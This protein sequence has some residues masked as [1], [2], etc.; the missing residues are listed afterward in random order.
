M[1]NIDNYKNN[2]EIESS[3]NT[4]SIEGM[5]SFTD[6]S[7]NDQVQG[8]SGGFLITIDT[9]LNE[10]KIIMINDHCQELGIVFKLKTT[11]LFYK[12]KLG[13]VHKVPCPQNFALFHCVKLN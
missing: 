1:D 6:G 2:L 12:Q 3:I 4:T 7:S 11:A 5:C 10:Q 8:V 13:A 9:T